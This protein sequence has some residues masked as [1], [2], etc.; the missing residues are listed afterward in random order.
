[1][2][3]HSSALSC[4]SGTGRSRAVQVKKDFDWALKAIDIL[5]RLDGVLS[6]TVESWKSF[7][8]PDEDIGYFRGICARAQR[9]LR[10][11]RSSFRELQG[12][13]KRLA[14]LKSCCTDFSRAVS[15]IPFPS[16]DNR[17]VIRGKLH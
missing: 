13:Q 7:N 17:L 11:I 8:S 4:S 3:E 6:H 15:H 16:A 10:A 2:K 12:D 5:R 14:L 1:M 9:S